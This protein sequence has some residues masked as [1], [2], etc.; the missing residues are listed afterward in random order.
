[1]R[2]RR[3]MTGLHQRFASPDAGHRH[4]AVSDG[5][6]EHDYV[7]IESWVMLKAPR[8]TGSVQAAVDL[9]DNDQRPQRPEYLYHAK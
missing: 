7:R 9:V 3:E 2:P 8:G 5:L 4:N 1:M 6:P